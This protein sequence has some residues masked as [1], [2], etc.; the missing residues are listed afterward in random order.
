MIEKINIK[1]IIYAII[2]K[3]NY[4]KEGIEFFT[5]ED[6][7]QQLAYMKRPKGYEIKPHL[8]IK[9]LKQ[10]TSTQEVLFIKSGKVRVDFYD[11]DKN[12]LTS[13]I[14]NV[15]DIILLSEGGHGFNIIEEAEI[16][17]IKQGPFDPAKDKTRFDAV[18]EENIK[19][20]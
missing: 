19:I 17:E 18:K 7:S 14:L 8:H 2:I 11:N 12:Y 4:S 20:K 16:I 5:P 6:F 9:S 13:R 15:G 1:G 3:S 10:T